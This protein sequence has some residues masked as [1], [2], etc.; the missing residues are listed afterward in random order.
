ME[1]IRPS[2]QEEYALWYLA[3]ER[4]K[5]HPEPVT[6]DPA[7][8]I[9]AMRER[10]AGKWRAWF[11]DAAWSV[12][13]LD[14]TDLHELVFLESG[15]T[16]NEGLVVRDDFDYRLLIRVAQ[17]AIANDYLKRSSAAGMSITTSGSRAVTA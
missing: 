17:R 16:K 12:A 10:H 6:T 2:S 9:Q 1:N 5:G 14:L 3:R 7:A 8:A 11:D 15:W 4:A 13:L